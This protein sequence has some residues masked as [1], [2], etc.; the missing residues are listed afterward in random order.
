MDVRDKGVSAYDDSPSLDVVLLVSIVG[1]ITYFLLVLDL[2][3]IFI[4]F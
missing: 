1:F 2:P 4:G 3:L